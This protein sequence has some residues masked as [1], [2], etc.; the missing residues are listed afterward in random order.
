[1]GFALFAVGQERYGLM[2]LIV[3]DTSHHYLHVNIE[4]GEFTTVL[5]L[6]ARGFDVDRG[7]EEEIYLTI[8]Q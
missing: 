6:R 8:I 4:D 3:Q 7:R 1:M 2:M 5:V